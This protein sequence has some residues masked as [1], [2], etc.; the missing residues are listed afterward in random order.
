MLIRVTVSAALLCEA[1]RSQELE[2][3]HRLSSMLNTFIDIRVWTPWYVVEIEVPT[4]VWVGCE[5]G[6]NLA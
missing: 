3:E 2:V 6:H 4:S 5:F 1:Q